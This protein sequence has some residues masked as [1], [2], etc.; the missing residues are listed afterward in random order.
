[1][2]PSPTNIIDELRLLDAPRPLTPLEW[3]LI[4][5]AAAAAAGLVLWLRTRARRRATPSPQVIAEAQENALAELGKLRGMIAVTNSKPYAIAVSGVVRRY[6]E[7]RFGLRAPRRSSEEFLLEAQSSGRL[8]EQHRRNLA[9]FLGACD[10]LKFARASAEVPELD[11]IHDTAVRFV[12]DT[13]PRPAPDGPPAPQ[14]A[15]A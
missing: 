15:G 3:L 4:L 14:E 6:I 5:L 10:F 11:T 8:E 12:M 13:E 7:R 1:V 9:A 2:K